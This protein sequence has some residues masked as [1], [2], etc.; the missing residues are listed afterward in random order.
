VVAVP[1]SGSNNNAIG[2]RLRGV[3]GVQSAWAINHGNAV[4]IAVLDT[5]ITSHPDLAGHVLPGYDMVSDVEDANDGDGR[6]P[7][8]S[9]PGDWVSQ[10][11][12]TS[13]PGKF[14]SCDVANSSWHGTDIAGILAAVTNNGTGGAAI[15]WN[16]R[17]VP[18]R[19]AGKCGAE[20]ADLI[21]GMRWAAGLA[22]A[23]GSGFLPLNPNP[24]RVVS[25][26]F[27][28]SAACG[29][30]Y[31][32]AVDELAANGVVVV[33][34]AGNDHAGVTRP[35]SCAGAIGV[36]ALNR[37]GFKAT[38]SNFGPQLTV[39][40]VG[41][42][43]QGDG[44]WGALLADDGVLTLDNDGVQAPRNPIYSRLF[45]TSF[46]APIAA[47]TIG[48]MLSVNP[49][50]TVAQIINGLKL[51]ARPHVTSPK[52]GTCSDANPGRCICTTQTCGAGILDAEQA[53]LYAQNPSGYVAPVR[54]PAVIDNAEVDAAVALGKDCRPTPAARRPLRAAAA[55]HWIRAG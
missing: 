10:A 4:P 55:V 43:W 44:A 19:V 9:D 13:N 1:V 11:D 47:G 24:V 39:S 35:A 52:I 48:L 51:S 21:D 14:G 42:D 33:A 41:G 22:V 32:A 17:V 50:L 53:V 45:G 46:A 49:N 30:A 40:T 38:Y 54:Q 36:A 29:A 16:G 20:V 2:A 28:S 31:Q 37:D 23:S 12:K 7:D 5:G 6:D 15:N 26:S 34:A 25:I 27:G 8:A 3:P 18:V